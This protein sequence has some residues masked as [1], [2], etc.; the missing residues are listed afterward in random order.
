MIAALMLSACGGGGGDAGKEAA[1]RAFAQC[2]A[3][4]AVEPGKRGVGPSL[5]GAVGRKAGALP[6]YN[7]S[8]ALANSGLVWD[9][10]TLDRFLADPVGTVPG[11]RMVTVV[12]SGKDRAEIIAYLS[13]IKA[14]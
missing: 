14:Q 5:A 12:R 2:A 10:G 7:Y 9:A 1:P 6:A 13:S 8:T 3:C 4:H 11:T